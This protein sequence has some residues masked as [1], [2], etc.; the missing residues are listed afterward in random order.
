MNAKLFWILSQ[1]GSRL[2]LRAAVFCVAGIA[3]APLGVAANDYLP[4]DLS[5]KIGAGSVDD[6]LNIIAS[7]MLAVTTFSLSIMVAA[8]ATASS[9]ATPCVTELLLSDTT[10]QNA[11]SVFIGAFLFSLAAIITRKIGIYGDN[12][13]LVLFIVTIVVILS[14][15]A[16][17]LRWIDHLSRLGRIGHTIDMV[18]TQARTTMARYRENPLLGA[19]P[20]PA[21]LPAQSSPL[22]SDKIGYLQNIDTGQL[23]K[24]AAVLDINIYVC[25]RP[26]TFN[27]GV[28]PLLHT[29]RPVDDAART[30]ILGT[31]AI[32]DMRSFTQDPRYCMIVLSEI[33]SRALSPAVND[34]GTAIDIIGTQ[35][36][37]LAPL[38]QPSTLTD[39]QAQ[40][41]ANVFLAG[42]DAQDLIDDAFMAIA[43]D[44]AATFEV[45][46]RLQKALATL[47]AL[48][49]SAIAVASRT[50]AHHAL[51]FSDAALTLKTQQAAVRK[52]APA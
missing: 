49:N 25:T 32:G 28:S 34:P 33:A 30:A 42:I 15:V 29:S 35:L 19:M 3:I 2:W 40:G 47:A 26:G 16:M 11:L 48:P 38:A 36:R 20:L 45:C 51:E 6:I 23:Q 10:S 39:P 12:G 14:I 44:G 43:R 21:E 1:F 7:S 31:I 8:Y 22:T 24:I 5:Y 46:I 41:H 50:A 52:V 18:E 17:L 9:A 37:L 4:D 13:R 27:N